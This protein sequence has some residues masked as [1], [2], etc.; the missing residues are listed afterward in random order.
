MSREKPLWPGARIR[1][2]GE[3]MPN[4]N[5]NNILGTLYITFDVAFP[6]EGFS[7]SQKQGKNLI[8]VQY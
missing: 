1:K 3:G 8:C 4:Y 5:N 2:K 6:K 7:D